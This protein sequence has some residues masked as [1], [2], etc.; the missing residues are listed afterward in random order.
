MSF[1]EV[2]SEQFP[3]AMLEAD[4]VDR[5]SRV[6]R[7][8]HGFRPDNA[9]A[10][11]GVCRD[12]LCRPLSVAV[13]AHWQ[14]TFSLHSLAA[15]V[16]VGKTGFAAV[17]SHAPQVDGR[18]R[19]V[20]FFAPHMGLGPG[21]E[22]GDVQ[23]IGHAGP[24]AA[25]GA[26]AAFLAELHRGRI[27]V[28]FDRHD[29]EQSLLKQRLLEELDLRRLPNLLALTRAAYAAGLADIEGL[30]EDTLDPARQDY[31][32]LTGIQIHGPEHVNHLWPGACY[33]VVGGQRF[34]ITP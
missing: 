33:A 22:P 29:I 10:C 16:I 13:Q 28:R 7:G 9:L 12:E 1:D 32:V 4:F 34:D 11:V 8:A 14:E 15:M 20:F 6:L 2:L 19:Y 31:A 26:L 21:G 17:R 25:C 24:T 27:D 23:R 18:E 5:C 30:I 3:G